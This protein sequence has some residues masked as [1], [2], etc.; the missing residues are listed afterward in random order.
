[1]GNFRALHPGYQKNFGTEE[2]SGGEAEKVIEQD[3]LKGNT[4]TDVSRAFKAVEDLPYMTC[5]LLHDGGLTRS[6]DKSYMTKVTN[7][8]K[9]QFGFPPVFPSTQKKSCRASREII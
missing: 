2:K 9:E 4:V 8:W 6:L 5:A 1:M 7:I 3:L